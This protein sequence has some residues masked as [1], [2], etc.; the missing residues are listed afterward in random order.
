VTPYENANAVDIS[1]LMNDHFKGQ[2]FIM[3]YI[4]IIRNIGSTIP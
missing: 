3:L 4:F 2:E 1:C